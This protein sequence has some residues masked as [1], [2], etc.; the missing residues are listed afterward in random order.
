MAKLIKLNTNEDKSG[1]LSVFEKVFE[2]D[3]K[4]VFFIYDLKGNEDRGGHRHKE[5]THA[6]ICQS[7][8]CKVLVND[9]QN[10]QTFLLDKPEV[11]LIVDPNEWR[12]MSDFSEN[13]IL[14]CI[15]N[16]HYDADDYIFEPYQND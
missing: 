6:L 8:S 10:I 15:S 16:K 9:G 1:K 11:C 2:D 14:L 12:E 3:I 4:R 7:G 13:A 5:S